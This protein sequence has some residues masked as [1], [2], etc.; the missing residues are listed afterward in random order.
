M[1]GFAGVLLSV[2]ITWVVAKR[3]IHN[4]QIGVLLVIPF[5]GLMVGST[6]AGIYTPAQ[7]IVFA[8]FFAFPKTR[9]HA[10]DRKNSLTYAPQDRLAGK[11]M[12]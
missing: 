10:R 11:G 8:I 4:R 6:V 1:L 7:W 12:L 9:T 3:L 2:A 5:I